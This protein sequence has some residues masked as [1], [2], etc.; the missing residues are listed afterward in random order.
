MFV[1]GFICF[2]FERWVM[3][4]TRGSL[5]LSRVNDDNNYRLKLALSRE[6]VHTRFVS[7]S[8]F[9]GVSPFTLSCSSRRYENVS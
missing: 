1:F 3:E 2:E 9:K 6:V 4:F 8:D 7:K 5:A